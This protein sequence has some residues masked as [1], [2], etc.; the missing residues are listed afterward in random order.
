MGV[1]GA[2]ER[3]FEVGMR[4]VEGLLA[5]QK[6][7]K[8]WK[9]GRLV[10]V[11]VVV[12]STNMTESETSSSLWISAL[13]CLRW[14]RRDVGQRDFDTSLFLEGAVRIIF[15]HV[16]ADANGNVSIVVRQDR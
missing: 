3:S 2:V 5:V 6:G 16:K 15:L 14:Y 8:G 13:W 10:E 12:V 11:V 4:L 1:K 9:V 7:S